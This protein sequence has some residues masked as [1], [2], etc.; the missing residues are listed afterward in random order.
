MRRS[1]LPLLA[2][3]LLFGCA[4]PIEVPPNPAVGPRAHLGRV[5]VRSASVEPQTN[6]AEVL[7]TKGQA[8]A[9]GAATGAL[10]GVGELAHGLASCGGAYCGAAFMVLLPVFV[11]T[12]AI[13]NAAGAESRAIVEDGERAMRRGLERMQLQSAV[14]QRLEKALAVRGGPLGSPAR[15]DIEVRRLEVRESAAPGANAPRYGLVLTTHA[16]LVT[17]EKIIDELTYVYSSRS[18]PALDWL[19]DE[20]RLFVDE[21]HTASVRT[22]ETLADELL[23]LYYPPRPADEDKSLVPY[24]ALKPQYPEP[25][26]SIDIRGAWFERYRQSWGGLQFVPVDSLEPV[27]RWERFPRALDV[28]AVGGASDRFTDVSYEFALYEAQRIGVIYEH[29]RPLYRRAGLSEPRYRLEPLQPCGRYVWTV[30]AWFRLDG[31]PRVTEWSGAYNAFPNQQ[32]WEQRRGLQT[33]SM[34]RWGLQPERFYLPFRAPGD[35]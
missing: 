32:P 8:A 6:L 10:M 20:A 2:A 9:A 19:A 23:F 3:H 11:A 16:R 26:R 33:T 27:F 31:Q 5:D 29:G 34:M 18:A 17:G 13:A 14:A 30:R 1:V 25:V 12:G 7:R 15:I 4:T 22:A 21:V 35:C 28:A 24:Y